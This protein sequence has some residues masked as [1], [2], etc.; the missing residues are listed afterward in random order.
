MSVTMAAAGPWNRD[1]ARGLAPPVGV[2]TIPDEGD[3][4]EIGGPGDGFSEVGGSPV[5]ARPATTFLGAMSTEDLN[6][7]REEVGALVYVR[8]SVLDAP[9]DALIIH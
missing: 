8:G 4:R 3:D 7:D 1:E 6:D 5:P 9:P 2:I